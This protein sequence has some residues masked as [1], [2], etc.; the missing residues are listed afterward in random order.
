MNAPAT[1]G[2]TSRPR[3]G[4]ESGKGRLRTLVTL[5]LIGAVAY[6]GFKL[7]PIRAAAYQLD[8]AVRDQVVLA[9]SRRRRVTDEE[10]RRTIVDRAGDLGLPVM[11]RD[12]NIRRTANTIRIEASYAVLVEFPFF[13]FSW[14][15]TAS[16][17][18][19]IF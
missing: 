3:S 1:T 4:G 19:P 14:P 13:A 7:I 9:G 5:V 10:M 2:A 16:H 17:E 8:D 15:F 18:G 6:T 11:A 12:V